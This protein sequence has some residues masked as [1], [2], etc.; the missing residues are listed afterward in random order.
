MKKNLAGFSLVELMIAVTL[1]LVLLSGI[2]QMLMGGRATFA[3]QQAVSKVQESG[4]L[5]IDF[6]AKDVRMAGY[7]GCASRKANTIGSTLLSS[8]NFDRNL[9]VGIQGYVAAKSGSAAL[10]T[11]FPINVDSSSTDVV[12]VSNSDILVLSVVTPLDVSINATNNE[13]ELYTQ[14]GARVGSCASGTEGYAGICAGDFLAVSDC[15][16]TQIFQATAISETPSKWIIE[17]VENG[18]SA[19]NS[20]NS[21]G[22]WQP[23]IDSKQR[24]DQGAY[25]FKMSRVAYFIGLNPTSKRTSLYQVSNGVTTELVE[26]I[27]DMKVTYGLDTDTGNTNLE[28]VADTYLTAAQIVNTGKS[29]DKVL[30]VRIQLLVQSADNALTEQR[31]ITFNGSP[32]TYDAKDLKLR[33]VFVS[34]VGIRNRIM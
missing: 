6:M 25:L 15:E 18:T 22:S 3:A 27:E 26:G 8:T 9:T 11:G 2:I 13:D 20:A 30:S 16:Y 4:R 10:P 5:A 32:K 33:Q 12:A 21:V 14:V 28:T 23:A 31:S 24:F 34:T 1:G 17:H 29:W 19:P 7:T